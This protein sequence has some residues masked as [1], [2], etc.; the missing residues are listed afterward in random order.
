[1]N[2]HPRILVAGC[3][4]TGERCADLFFSGGA[5]VTGLVSSPESRERL[6]AKPY[7]VLAADAADPEDL[8]R[9]LGAAEL[10][11][12]ILIHCL[13][14]KSGRDADAYRRVYVE[15]LRQLLAAAAPAFSVFTSSTSVYAHDDGSLVDENSAV[16]GTPTGGVLVE[17]ERLALDAGGAAVRLGGIYGPGRARFLAA[18]RSGEPLPG[19]AG[20]CINLIHVDDAAAALVHVALGRLPGAFNAVDD[21]PVRRADLAEAIRTDSTSLPAPA[22]PPR[23]GKRVSNA[24]L[25]ATGWTPR[26]PSVLDALH[27]GAV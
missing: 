7:P 12:D 26:Y 17:A 5:R 8:A 13:S 1:L 3:G 20:A 11:V 2:H 16:G 14:G 25:R 18:V 23:A 4:Y 15:T 9:A 27:A 24:R 19:D 21:H 6:S 10:P 22:E